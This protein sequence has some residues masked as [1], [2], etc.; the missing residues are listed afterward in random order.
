MQGCTAGGKMSDSD[1]SKISDCDSSTWI[2]PVNNFVAISTQWKSWYTARIL[3][4]NKRFKWNC[5]I[6]TRIPNLGVWYYG[7]SRVGVGQKN[8]TPT[9][10][11]V[12]HRTPTPHKNF[13]LLATPQPC[14]NMPSLAACNRKGYAVKKRI[15][16]CSQN[17]SASTNG[18]ASILV[19]TIAFDKFCSSSL[20]R[21]FVSETVCLTNSALP[22]MRNVRQFNVVTNHVV[23]C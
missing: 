18:V 2:L 21:F 8:P 22:R 17:L 4:F 3:C 6:S 15:R 13:Q 19:K 12:R 20:L 11:V 10:S 5:T 7:T 9:P 23:C 14:C 16:R 1:L